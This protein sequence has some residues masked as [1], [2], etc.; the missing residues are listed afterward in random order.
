MI[1]TYYE[2]K[3]LEN[4][5]SKPY[6]YFFLYIFDKWVSHVLTEKKIASWD[7]EIND[8]LI[9]DAT[10]KKTVN[11]GRL[12]H[13]RHCSRSPLFEGD[14]Q[15]DKMILKTKSV[16][17]NHKWSNGGVKKYIGHEIDFHFSQPLNLHPA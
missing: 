6:E 15:L 1:I 11:R 13:R 4:K 8:S 16:A 5:C 17:F 10:M 3:T 2:A 12:V 14:M 9:E 7:T